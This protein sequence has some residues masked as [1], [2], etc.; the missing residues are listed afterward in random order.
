MR[1]FKERECRISLKQTTDSEIYFVHRITRLGSFMRR[2]D[3]HEAK[4]IE[5][6]SY[7]DILHVKSFTAVTEPHQSLLSQ[8]AVTNCNSYDQLFRMVLGVCRCVIHTV[9]E[10]QPSRPASA[11]C[12]PAVSVSPKKISSRQ[13]PRADFDSFTLN[14][15]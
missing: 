7:A 3:V 14:R 8:T 13:N 4:Q 6:S 1:C 15:S 10:S 9:P 12:C 11:C 5:T 2:F